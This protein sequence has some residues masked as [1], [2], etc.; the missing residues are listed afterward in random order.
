M[1]TQA[2]T[3]F[4]MGLELETAGKLPLLELQQEFQD[5]ILGPQADTAFSQHIGHPSGRSDFA[6]DAR[7]AIYY[8]AYRLRLR[9][10][11]S[12]AFDKT[13]RYIGD[14]LFHQACHAYCQTHP[15]LSR[16][17][18]WYG[19]KFPTFLKNYLSDYPIAAELAE[20]EWLL[21]LAFDAEDQPVLRLSD[22]ATVAP[23]DWAQIGFVCQ[24][25]QHFLHARWNSVALWMAL[26]EQAQQK[27]QQQSPPDPVYSEE[28]TVW[29]IWRKDLQAHFRSISA[30]EYTAL[31]GLN[32]GQSFAEVC[33]TAAEKNPDSTMQI[34]GWLQTWLNE[35]LLSAVR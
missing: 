34:A 12:D 24:A 3:T 16:N 6:T 19:A 22:M 17:L 15:S 7:L 33:E 28:G 29:L 30:A 13:H 11:L 23:E 27:V 26:G 9:E 21:S 18:R 32:E 8:D 14:D 31:T 35:D 1:S 25:S 20:F 2:S 10:A 4:G 5:F